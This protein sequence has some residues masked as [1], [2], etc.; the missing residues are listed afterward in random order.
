[1]LGPTICVSSAMMGNCISNQFKH[2]A[3][4]S[5]DQLL[6]RPTGA[7]PQSVIWQILYVWALFFSPKDHPNSWLKFSFVIRKYLTQLNESKPDQVLSTV[8][9]L[10]LLVTVWTPHDAIPYVPFFLLSC[11]LESTRSTISFS[12]GVITLSKAR[13][14]QKITELPFA[15]FRAVHVEMLV[16][17]GINITP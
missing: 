3:I 5:F 17:R 9:L 4:K 1:M 7:C 10:L 14:V 12:T 2:S 8:V 16:G 11:K 15:P 13:T 6:V